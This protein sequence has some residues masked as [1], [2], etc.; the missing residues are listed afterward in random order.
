MRSL[1]GRIA[2]LAATVAVITGVLAGGLT[3]GLV[4]SAANS[5]AQRALSRLADAAQ[6]TSD[7]GADATTVQVRRD[8][9]RAISAGV[10]RA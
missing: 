6:S 4:R 5:E 3:V 7:I 9:R 2:W 10:N 8:D 1:V